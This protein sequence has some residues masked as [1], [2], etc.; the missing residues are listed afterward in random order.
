MALP[1]ETATDTQAEEETVGEVEVVSD[2]WQMGGRL[3][4]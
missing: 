3:G 4:V 1:I 2:G